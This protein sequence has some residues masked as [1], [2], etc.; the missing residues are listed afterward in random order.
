M[1]GEQS[2]SLGLTRRGAAPFWRGDNC[3]PLRPLVFPNML[4]S[5]QMF[6]FSPPSTEAGK[7]NYNYKPGDAHL[8]RPAR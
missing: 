2:H 1:P 7:N 3:C 8:D 5:P 6:L 4:M